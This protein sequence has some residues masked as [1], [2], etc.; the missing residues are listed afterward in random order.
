M[1]VIDIGTGAIRAGTS[2]LYASLG[3]LI[4]ERA[5]VVNLG[6]EGSMLGG[7]LGAFAV[8]VWS[9]NPWLGALAGGLCGA[10]FRANSCFSRHYTESECV[11]KR[12][13]RD[14]LRDRLNF[15]PRARLREQANQWIRTNFHSV[16]FQNPVRRPAPIST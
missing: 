8:T 1:N 5:G 13:N 12:L 7:A 6:T 4:A 16:F 3:E 9:G 11:S 10:A 2:V 15:F 14:V